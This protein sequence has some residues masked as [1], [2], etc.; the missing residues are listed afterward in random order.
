MGGQRFFVDQQT[1]NEKRRETEKPGKQSCLI[2]SNIKRG[3]EDN[4]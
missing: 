4:V 3:G 2:I 1:L